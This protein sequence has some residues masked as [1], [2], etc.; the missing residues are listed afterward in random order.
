MKRIEIEN[1]VNQNF[2][3]ALK[4]YEQ[5]QSRLKQENILLVKKNE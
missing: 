3:D 1:K 4:N 5:K 2:K